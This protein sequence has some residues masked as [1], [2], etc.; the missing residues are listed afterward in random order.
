MQFAK[1]VVISEPNMAEPRAIRIAS[2]VPHAAAQLSDAVVVGCDHPA[3]ARRYLLI[4]IKGEQGGVSKRSSPPAV[5]FCSQSFAS[6]FDN[7]ESIFPSDF[8]QL[9]HRAGQTENVDWENCFPN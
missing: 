7:C 3:F 1:A 9:V 6:I 5:K 2:L 8:Y 4:G